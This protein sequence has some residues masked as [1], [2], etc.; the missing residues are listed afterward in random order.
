MQVI[1]RVGWDGAIR[2]PDANELGWKETVRMNPLED[3][4]VAMRPI[5]AEAARSGCPTASARWTPTHA[6][7]LRRAVLERRP[8]PAT[9]SPSPTHSY[10]FGWEYVWHCHLLGH[11]ENDMMR[12]M[13]FNVP[14]VLPYP[15]DPLVLT[16][17]GAQINV[18]WPDGTPFNYTT[19]LPTDTLGNPANEIGFRIE[20]S[21]DNVNYSPLG[22]ALANSTSFTDSTVPAFSSGT[23]YWYRVIAYNAA[24]E[25]PSAVATI[26]YVS[27]LTPA[28][29]FTGA[30]ASAPYNTS[31]TVTATTNAST[32]P[33]I[34]GTPGV[35]SVGPVSGISTLATALVTMTSGT[36]TCALTASWAA[37]TSHYAATATQ[38]TVAALVAPTVTFTGAPASAL[39]RLDLPRDGHD[40]RQHRADHHGYWRVCVR[41][42]QRQ[43]RHHHHDQRHGRLRPHRELGRGPQLPCGHRQP[44]DGGVHALAGRQPD[45]AGVRQPAGRH[46]QRHPDRGRVQYRHHGRYVRRPHVHRPVLAERRIVR[47]EPQRRSDV[48]D[49]REVQTAGERRGHRPLSIASSAPGSPAIVALSGNGIAPVASVSPTALAFSTPLNVPSAPQTITVTNIGTAPLTINNV[50]RTGANPN[51]FAQTNNCVGSLPVSGTCTITVTFSPTAANPLTKTANLNV[52]VAAPATNATV[53]LT[54]TLVVPTFSVSPNPVAF[55]PQSV[56]AGAKVLP[57]TIANTGAAPLR[58]ISISRSGGTAN[59]FPAIINTSCPTSPATL[60]AGASCTVAAS[61]DPTTAGAKNTNLN[62]SVGA[63]AVNQSVPMTG[64]GTTP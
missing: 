22:N 28:V 26:N 10:N 45:L 14:R 56:S 17:P 57:V 50:T 46:E 32:V 7:G 55:G 6:A 34:V 5:D 27:L 36:G 24:G 53:S 8:G 60:A 44:V 43:Q 54:G 63:P 4:I 59:Q 35:C 3:I 20:R 62:V 23:D 61:F 47:R 1:N 18:Q 58:I 38:A 33:T 41:T 31:F 52:V 49:R 64:T 37:D 11:E 30:P 2:P 13:V 25:T 29:T 39:E 19:G 40:Q 42:L 48:H 12:P 15:P 21:P 9:R 51:Q 16:Q